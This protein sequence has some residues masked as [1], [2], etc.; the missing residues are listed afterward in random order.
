MT[1]ELLV[2]LDAHDTVVFGTDE[3]K[4]KIIMALNYNFDKTKFLIFGTRQD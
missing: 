4:I 1:M 2:L 3:K